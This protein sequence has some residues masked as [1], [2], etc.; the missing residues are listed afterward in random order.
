MLYLLQQGQWLL[1]LGILLAL[2]ISLSFHEFGHAWA[3]KRFGDN[4][5]ELAGRLTINP[6]SHID[7]MGLLMVIMIGF[8]Y[9]KPVPT[10]PR[11]FTSRYADLVIAAA[12]PLMNLLIAIASINFYIFTL[13][14]GW[15]FFEQPGTYFFFTYLAQI[16]LLL[17]VFNL[18]P[19][20]ALDGNY[21]LPYFLPRK[22]AS[23]YRFYNHRYGNWLLLGL[24]FL[25]I[26]GVPVFESVLSMSRSMLAL[27]VFFPL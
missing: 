18:L 8:G 1:F 22:L 23:L 17:M 21:I 6:R 11:L 19:I 12:G 3:A 7:P 13:Q 25:A 24:L 20:G 4:T 5:A 10:N 14:A 9:A 2:V 15:G 26:L 16:N 27:I